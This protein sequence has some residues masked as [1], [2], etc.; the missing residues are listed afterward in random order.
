[1]RPPR[2]RPRPRQSQV[3]TVTLHLQHGLLVAA[4]GSGLRPTVFAEAAPEP[5]PEAMEVD[6]AGENDDK[7]KDEPASALL[8][9]PARVTADQEK[10][11]Q[12]ED[13]RYRMVTPVSARPPRGERQP[14]AHARSA[15][16]VRRAAPHRSRRPTV[17]AR[18]GEAV[19]HHHRHRHDAGGAG[20]ARQGGRPVDEQRRRCAPRPPPRRRRAARGAC[21]RAP[22]RQSAGSQPQPQPQSPLARGESVI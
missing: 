4:L 7:K 13:K 11:I 21:A 16:S 3:L 14:L 6:E 15:V 5:E 17:L 1:M 18:A 8:P 22:G 19:R 2:R 10:Y 20:G 9:N 12:W